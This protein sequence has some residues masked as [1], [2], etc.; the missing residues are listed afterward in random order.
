MF[1]N[2]RKNRFVTEFRAS[3]FGI[4]RIK[5]SKLVHAI[6]LDFRNLLLTRLLVTGSYFL[7]H[8]SYNFNS[9]FRFQLYLVTFY[10]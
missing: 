6:F 2:L 9:N 7:L 1:Y 10:D 3:V 8:R 5:V 4:I